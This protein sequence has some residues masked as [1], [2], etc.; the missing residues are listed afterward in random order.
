[1]TLINYKSN[2]T[3]STL[4]LCDNCAYGTGVTGQV[5]LIIQGVSFLVSVNVAPSSHRKPT[6]SARPVTV[7]VLKQSIR[8]GRYL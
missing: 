3:W 2:L 8:E 7:V 6:V 5:A 4:R 1:M